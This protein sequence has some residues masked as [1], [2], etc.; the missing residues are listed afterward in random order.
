M[1]AQ[2]G[3]KGLA[4]VKVRE[5]GEW[6]SPIAKFFTD[7]ERQADK[8]TALAAA[9]GDVLFFVADLPA[10]VHQALAELRLELAR[11]LDTDRQEAYLQ[12]CLDSRFSL[13]RI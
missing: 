7:Q 10:I 1:S 6:Q 11:K 8:F 3:A 9:E 12:L 2:F 5:T 13:V 4:W